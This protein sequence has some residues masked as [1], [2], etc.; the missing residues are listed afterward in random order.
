MVRRRRH[1]HERGRGTRGAVRRNQRRRDRGVMDTSMTPR[2]I[3]AGDNGTPKYEKD[4]RGRTIY[5]LKKPIENGSEQIT[6][7]RFRP[8][9]AKDL[10]GL[11]LEGRTMSHILDIVGKVCGQPPHVVDELT[12]ED[13]EEV[14]SI[15]GV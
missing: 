3:G 9:K 4:E 15:V 13:F 6:E 2:A 5:P 8:L 1:R 14:S 7:L 11:P 10:R 12:P